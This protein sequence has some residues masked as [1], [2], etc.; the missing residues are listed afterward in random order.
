MVR[1]LPALQIA[2]VVVWLTMCCAPAAAQHHHP[3]GGDEANPLECD[4]AA[5]EACFQALLADHSAVAPLH[6]GR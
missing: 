6:P 4:A 3:G 1:A 5:G 2:L